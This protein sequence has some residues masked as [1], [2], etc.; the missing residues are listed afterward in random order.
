M[1]EITF[2]GTSSAVPNKDHQNTHIIIQSGDRVILVDCVGNPVI[3]LGQAGIDPKSITDLILTHFHPD[4]VSGVPLLLM[5]SWLLGREKHIDVYGLVGVIDRL[6]RMMDLFDWQEW[7]GFYPVNFHKQPTKEYVSLIDLDDVQV[8]ASPVCHMIPTIGL[9][10]SF[11]E[12][13]LCY[14]S[15][16]APCDAM[17]RL[18]EGAD[19]LIHEA[20]GAGIGHSSP[21]Q[22]GE[23]AQRAGVDQLFL[24]HYPPNSDVQELI[25]MAKIRFSG[26][27]MIAQDLMTVTI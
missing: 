21:E 16:T 10:M 9:K 2:L 3:R 19:I 20:T 11:P 18:A 8:W 7:E 27:V 1:T 6:Q 24:I 12:G 13:I 4:H 26:E 17:V 15:D 22:A 5:D 14:S 25:K 23:I